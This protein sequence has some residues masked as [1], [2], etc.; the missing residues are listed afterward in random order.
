MPPSIYQ[1]QEVFSKKICGITVLLDDLENLHLQTVISKHSHSLS[2]ILQFSI[3]QL[4][5]IA[6]CLLILKNLVIIS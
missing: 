1:I 5:I 2:H 6:S 4:K 3:L